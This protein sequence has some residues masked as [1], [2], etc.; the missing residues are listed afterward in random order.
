MKEIPILFSTEMV[1]AELDGSKT[2]T[3]RI[4][5]PQPLKADIAKVPTNGWDSVIP[6][7]P[8]GQPGDLLWVRE[9]H[10]ISWYTNDIMITYSDG[11]VVVKYYL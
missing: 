3:R 1:K 8:F 9:T 10:N 4:M 7:C 6:M 2:M 5:N 11:G